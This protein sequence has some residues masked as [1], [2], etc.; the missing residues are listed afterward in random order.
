VLT[1][2]QGRSEASRARARAAGM[3]DA[4]RRAVE[5]YPNNPLTHVELARAGDAETIPEAEA[6]ERGS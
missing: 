6:S 2:L 4:V 3:E 1:S 5:Y